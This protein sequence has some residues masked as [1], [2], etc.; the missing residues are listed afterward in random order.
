MSGTVNGQTAESASRGLLASSSPVMQML[1]DYKVLIVLFAVML[2]LTSF[3]APVFFGPQNLINVA[4][5]A[6]ITGVVAVGMTFV[7]LTSG[8][9]LSVGS[10]LALVGVI[11][12]VTINNDAGVGGAIAAA[13]L[14]GGAVGVVNG[15]GVT[16]FGIQPFI[17]S[18]AT[19]AI[20][21]GVALLISNGTPIHFTSDNDMI[22]LLGNGSLGGAPG[23]VIVF[24]IVAIVATLSLRYLP[25]GRFVYGI[26]GGLEAARLS[27]VRTA[28]I[29]IIVYAI[30]GLCAAMAG[31]ITTSRLFVGHPTA[32]APIMLDSIAAV[33]IGGTSLMGGK[34]SVIGTVAGVCLLAM[35]TNLLNLLGVSPFN[36]QIA[37]GAIIILAVLFTAQ[38]LWP[39]IVQQWHAL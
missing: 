25:F 35:V 37:K 3:L 27:G 5:Q 8:I 9:D 22:A 28:R 23:P 15:L 30:S 14:V 6:S 12:S 34:G 19:M 1:N 13:L 38:G 33:V 16:F 7:V 31:I 21:S 32:G 39:R 18:L 26:G 36:Q 4:R 20:S 2:A 17:M 11:F 10:I 29:L 24:V